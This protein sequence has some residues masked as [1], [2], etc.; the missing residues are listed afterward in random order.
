MDEADAPH[1]AEVEGIFDLPVNLIGSGSEWVFQS[2]LQ[3]LR[4][5]PGSLKTPLM[6]IDQ[7][8]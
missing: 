2:S 7:S 8:T 3:K 6:G 4:P 1:Y 5:P